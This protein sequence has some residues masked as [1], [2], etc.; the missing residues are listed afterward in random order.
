MSLLVTNFIRRIEKLISSRATVPLPGTDHINDT[1][2]NTDI[3]PGELSIEL[4]KGSLYTTDGVDIIE[5]N[6]ENLILY[7][8]ELSKPTSGLLKLGVSSGYAVINGIT[9]F[10]TTTGTDIN[11]SANVGA[12]PN[13]V[14]VYAQASSAT[15]ASGPLLSVIYTSISGTADPN[16]VYASVADY[17]NIPTPPANSLLLGTALLYP[18]A[19]GYDLFPL[20]VAKLGDYYPKFSVTPSEFLRQ[21]V[22]DVSAYSLTQLYFPGQFVIDDNSNTIYLSKKT[23]VSD[24]SSIANDIT[25]SNLFPLGGSGT[26]GTASMTALNLGTGLGVYKTTVGTQFQFRTLGVTGSGLTL[27]Y[28]GS[29][30]EILIG[31]SFS[32]FVTQMQNIG[33]GATV[34]SGYTGA[35]GNIAQLRAISAGSN[36]TVGLSGSDILISVPAIGSTAQGVNLGA[37]ASAD[38]YAGMSGANLSFRRIAFGAGIT[39]SQTSDT[40]F[41]SSTGEANR[42]ANVGGASG[43]IYGG[44]SGTDLRF[45]SLTAGSNITITTIG[46]MIS[47]GASVSGGTTNGIAIGATGATV[48]QI[49]AGMSG[50]DILFRSI[51]EGPGIAVGNDGSGNVV[52]ASTVV[53]GTQGPQGA[54][55]SLGATGAQ[56][57]QGTGFTGATGIDGADGFQ[58][59]QGATGTGLQGAQ[60]AQGAAGAVSVPNAP[61]R[62]FDAYDY[63]AGWT[64]NAGSNI[65]IP[66]STTRYNSDAALFVSGTV[67]NPS[68]PNGTTVT[69]NEPGN[70]QII[71]NV[72]GIS[73]T[74][75]A[76]SALGTIQLFDVG[77]ST[78]VVGTKS[79]LNTAFPG[80]SGAEE[81]ATATIKVIVTIVTVT[82]YCVKF[83]VTG[84]SDISGV[85]EGSSLSI[86]KLESA[87]GAQGPSIQG[88]QGFQGVFGPQGA[89][90]GIIG[91]QGSTGATGSGTQGPQGPQG[92]QG[93]LGPQGST[94]ATGSGTQGP[95]GNQG[96]LGP[97]GATSGIIGPQGLAGPQ[98]LTGSQGLTGPQGLGLTGTSGPQGVAG[99][100]GYAG[101]PYIITNVQAGATYTAVLLDANNQ[102]A[103]NSSSANWVVIPELS[104]VSWEGG[105]QINIVQQGTGQTTISPAAGVTIYS[106]SSKTK[107]ASQYSSA[108]LINKVSA[109]GAT[110]NDWYLFGN[111]TL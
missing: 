52:I 100:Q 75:G 42:G 22:K 106:E 79:F 109:I 66:F 47:I 77:L 12:N 54:S 56:G 39:G 91:P 15:G 14:F 99:P 38:I 20:S 30:D 72:S 28:S 74:A 26:G 102:I 69:F 53:D 59:P 4:S 31:L 7:G 27:A 23:F 58:G 62:Y 107:L 49:Y 83:T 32:S 85:A 87:L 101:L 5:L 103:M 6:R 17:E 16:G 78:E 84:Y 82:T 96:I 86:M 67:S 105:T 41:L 43:L 29:T 10:H 61:M 55:G 40:I 90:S 98:G 111:L 63:S 80:T 64:V 70:Y 24:Y 71:A 44:L 9:Y 21:T 104:S 81:Y 94:G 60:G 13:L 89:T 48:G 93:V 73:N 88:P 11:I 3:Y 50:S 2:L 65:F 8:L 34:F 36:V 110:S 35:T 18:G 45:R 108:T 95:Q 97:Q 33:T 51:T 57:P 37:G 68:T 19:T 1:W 25:N 46:D 92:I 76:G